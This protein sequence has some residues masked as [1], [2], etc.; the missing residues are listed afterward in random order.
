MRERPRSDKNALCCHSPLSYLKEGESINTAQRRRAAR[1]PNAYLDGVGVDEGAMGVDEVHLGR[2]EH[3]MVDALESVELGIFAGH[4]V[5]PPE[6][7]RPLAG[8]IV[9]AAAV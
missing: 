1:G 4:H 9:S 3:P 5:A 8:T 6:P 7:P 2:S